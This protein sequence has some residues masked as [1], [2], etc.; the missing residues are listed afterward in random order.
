MHYYLSVHPQITQFVVLQSDCQ[1]KKKKPHKNKQVAEKYRDDA[2]IP[3]PSPSLNLPLIIKKTRLKFPQGS[4][5]TWQ[6]YK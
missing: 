1:K 5:T 6:S 2:H 3:P 4:V